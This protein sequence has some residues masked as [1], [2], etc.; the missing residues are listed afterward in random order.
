MIILYK[1][2]STLIN[3]KSIFCC[4]KF[5]E[6]SSEY[7]YIKLHYNKPHLYLDLTSECYACYESSLEIF[8]CPFCGEKFEFRRVFKKDDVDVWWF[9][10]I[11][12]K[13]A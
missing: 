5:K 12:I 10:W 11:R 8:Y 4:D 6:E 7:F 9:K 2:Y 13:K 3:K 1:K